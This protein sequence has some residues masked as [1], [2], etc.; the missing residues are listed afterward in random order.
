MIQAELKVPA[1]AFASYEDGDAMRLA[2]AVRAA[3]GLLGP[4]TLSRRPS[5]L[6]RVRS[7]G[8]VKLAKSTVPR[9][10][11]TER[12]YGVPH[13]MARRDSGGKVYLTY[14]W[15]A[16]IARAEKGGRQTRAMLGLPKRADDVGTSRL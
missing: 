5:A 3:H 2:L 14:V 9:M 11:S 4:P 15:R 12:A 8:T 6:D 16:R 10:L 1:P 7:W 13:G